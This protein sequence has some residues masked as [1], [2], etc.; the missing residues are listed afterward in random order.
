MPNVLITQ[1]FPQPAPVPDVRGIYVYNG[2]YNGLPSYRNDDDLKW[3][4]WWRFDYY[5]IS[6]HA[7][8]LGDAYWLGTDPEHT[9]G[10][11]GTAVNRVFGSYVEA[12]SASPSA[13]PSAP[14]DL[15][16]TLAVGSYVGPWLV[17]ADSVGP[18][19]HVPASVRYQEDGYLDLCIDDSLGPF[20]IGDSY[21]GP[22][23]ITE[24]SIGPF[25]VG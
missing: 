16:I 6:W 21:W 23:R 1:G 20:V 17:S 22:F 15:V 11:R 10:E 9:F 5:V 8:S 13:S 18:F 25:V 14:C 4:I 12:P 24:S 19:Q 7:G 3:Y 2:D